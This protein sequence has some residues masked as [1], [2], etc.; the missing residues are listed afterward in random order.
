MEKLKKADEVRSKLVENLL[1]TEI[2]EI[3]QSLSANQYSIYYGAKWHATSKSH[4]I[5]KSL[6]HVTKSGIVIGLSMLLR[7]KRVSWVKSLEDYVRFLYPGIMKS[8]EPYSRFDIVTDRY[9]SESLKEGVRDNRG[10]D[11]LVFPFNDSAP[12]S[13]NFETGFLTNVTNEINLNG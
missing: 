2:F 13:A 8:A 4:A 9:F 11:G 5:S 12:F 3:S 1:R 7:K 10:S 6:F